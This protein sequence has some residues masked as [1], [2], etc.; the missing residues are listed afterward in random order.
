[1]CVQ[2]VETL[3]LASAVLLPEHEETTSGA[4]IVAVEIRNQ[5]RAESLKPGN[6]DKSILCVC[7]KGIKKN[8]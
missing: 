5:R 7:R 4:H 6:P 8:G 3:Y 1:M 2:R